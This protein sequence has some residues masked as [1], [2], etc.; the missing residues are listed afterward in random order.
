M[1]K[2]FI[3]KWWVRVFVLLVI[4]GLFSGGSSTAWSFIFLTL[5]LLLL[6][7]I[8]V[9]ASKSRKLASGIDEVPDTNSTNNQKNFRPAPPGSKSKM[10]AEG[11]YIL[12]ESSGSYPVGLAG[13][14]NYF[15]A[16]SMAANRQSGEHLAIAEIVREPDNKFDTNA[17]RVEINGRTVGYIP[18]EEA[19][20]FH[21]LLSYAASINK[22]VFASCRVWVSDEDDAYGSVSLDIDDP[23][24]ALPPINAAEVPVSA[25]I[26]PIGS[27]LQVSEESKN[28]ENVKIVFEKM[29]EAL[30]RQILLELVIDR[31]KPEKPE[32]HVLFNGSKVGE[33]S[34]ASGRKFLPA[35]EKVTAIGKRLFVRGEAIGNSLA[36]EIKIF[37]K[38]PEL[39]SEKEVT[40]LLG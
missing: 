31:T 8:F 11:T 20:S 6:T 4:P 13:E 25:V 5:L 39:L 35:I 27:T 19:P 30:G 9:R 1:K 36:A 16:I 34:S 18:R 29:R 38:T 33:L 10:P 22:R 21:T 26:W 17:V 14:S 23:N 28:I 15:E 37:A 24:S 32:V 2:N 3:D 40:Q 12:L 7:R